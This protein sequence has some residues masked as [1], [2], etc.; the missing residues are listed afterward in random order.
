MQCNYSPP[1]VTGFFRTLVHGLSY[2]QYYSNANTLSLT[3]PQRSK[4]FSIMIFLKNHVTLLL[5]PLQFSIISRKSNFSIKVAFQ[6]CFFV[7]F[8]WHVHPPRSKTLQVSFCL[9]P[10]MIMFKD[11]ND[12]LLKSVCVFLHLSGAFSIISHY[13]LLPPL[14]FC[15]NARLCLF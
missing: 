8:W 5:L 9:H 7:C 11:T 4:C 14:R 10:I 15:H 12:H 2:P 6:F 13:M 1:F 3:V